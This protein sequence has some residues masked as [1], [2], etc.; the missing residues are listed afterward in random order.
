[1]AIESLTSS[2]KI[3]NEQL[4]SSLVYRVSSDN[5]NNETAVESRAAL[6]VSRQTTRAGAVSILPCCLELD[7]LSVHNEAMQRILTGIF[8]VQ[9]HD[10]L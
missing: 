1:M 3:G 2:T 5:T 10:Y 9:P 8:F 4:I 7:M 6:P